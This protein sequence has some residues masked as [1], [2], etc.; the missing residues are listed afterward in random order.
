MGNEV[1]IWAEGIELIK[2]CP[3]KEHIKLK[4]LLQTVYRFMKRL[5]LSI[6]NAS[7]IGKQ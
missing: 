4:S 6:K 5:N 7:H 1:I 2:K 3:E